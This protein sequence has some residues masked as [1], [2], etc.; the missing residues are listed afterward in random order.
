LRMDKP[1]IKGKDNTFFFMD[2]AELELISQSLPRF[3]WSRL[4]LP[5]LIEMAPD[6]G[7]NS[8]RIQGNVEVEVVSKILKKDISDMKFMIIYLPEVRELRRLLPTT[9]QY[10]FL[11]SIGDL[12]E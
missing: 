2:K 4:R 9:T 1:G 5:I 11:T 12:E 8:A 6:L 3:M 10:A 7:S